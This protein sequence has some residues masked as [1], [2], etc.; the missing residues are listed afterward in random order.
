MFENWQIWPAL[1]TLAGLAVLG[2][3]WWGHRRN[4]A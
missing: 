3:Q 2:R 4:D 1:L